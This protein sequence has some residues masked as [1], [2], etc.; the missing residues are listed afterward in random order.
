VVI[1]ALASGFQANVATDARISAPVQQQV[2]VALESGISVVPASTV[3]DAA[4]AAGVSPSE[5][6]A[7]VE[8]YSDAQLRA[9]QAGLLLAAFI[10]VGTFFTTR[11]LPTEV[12]RGDEPA[13]DPVATG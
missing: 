5:V 10:V 3:G 7:I 9:L 6:D 12:L 4:T 13:L 11:D 2:G 1:T 8:G